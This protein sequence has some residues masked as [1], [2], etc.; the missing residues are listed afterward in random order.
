MT[1]PN[2]KITLTGKLGPGNN[3]TALVIEYVTVWTI[4]FLA[5]IISITWGNS[6]GSNQKTQTFQLAT[7]ATLTDTITSNVHVIAIST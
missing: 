1:L 7:I 6:D 4:D 2:N 3:V 5:G